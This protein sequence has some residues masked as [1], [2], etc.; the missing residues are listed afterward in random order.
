MSDMAPRRH[1]KLGILAC[2]IAIGVWVYFAAAFYLIFYVEGFTKYLSDLFIPESR[3]MTDLSGM[4]AVV[5]LFAA[6]FFV[7]PAACHLFGSLLAVIGLFRSSR[8]RL[9]SALGLLLN[10]LPIFILF[11]L[12]V[13]GG[14][15]PQQ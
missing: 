9:F 1:S 11:V 5:V 15:N 2:L 10:L 12:F 14:L 4:G 3:G 7:I 8:K 13:I 6:I